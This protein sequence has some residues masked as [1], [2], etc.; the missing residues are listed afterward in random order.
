[1]LWRGHP[2]VVREVAD[3]TPGLRARRI[4]WIVTD[5]QDRRFYALATRAAGVVLRLPVGR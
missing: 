4:G 1:M 2:V 3:T 5:D